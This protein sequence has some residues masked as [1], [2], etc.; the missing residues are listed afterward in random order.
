MHIH[1]RTHVDNVFAKMD[2]LGSKLPPFMSVTD[3][4]ELIHE[5]QLLKSERPLK[6]LP[7]R[8]KF[9]KM[10]VKKEPRV[11]ESKKNVFNTSK[12]YN[13]KLKRI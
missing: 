4:V 2:S 5:V 1:T 12:N 8:M 10:Y 6:G 13:K 9:L 7:N 11:F 3:T